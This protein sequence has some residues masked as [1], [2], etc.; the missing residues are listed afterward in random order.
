[1][2]VEIEVAFEL[3]RRQWRFAGAGAAAVTDGASWYLQSRAIARV[4][5]L[6]FE[7]D[8]HSVD[9]IRVFGGH[10]PI[11]FP[12][13]RLDGPGAGLGRSLLGAGTHGRRTPR[14]PAGVTTAVVRV[15]HAFG[16]L[17]RIAGWPRLAGALRV[18]ASA[19]VASTADAVQVIGGALGQDVSWLF[20]PVLE[21]LPVWSYAVDSI[22]VESCEPQPCVRTRV[23]VTRLGSAT[24]AGR[25]EPRTGP[26]D[27]GDALQV[28]VGFADGQSATAHWDGRDQARAF[29]F[30]APAAPVEARLDPASMMLVDDNWLDQA[31]RVNGATNVP[32]TKWVSRWLIWLQ[33]AMLAYS[34]IV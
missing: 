8:G 13:L 29:T 25:R 18:L 33:Q 21:P 12:Q 9:S 7:H 28:R 16:S 6:V 31:R 23:N 11:A 2:D 24:F 3:A 30:E 19:R 10:Y 15:A 26:F 22:A 1:M 5:D 34:G 27:S 4:F 32:V 14:Y 17:E 20:A